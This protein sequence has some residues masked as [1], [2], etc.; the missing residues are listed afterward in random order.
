MHTTK[1]AQMPNDLPMALGE[2]LPRAD[3]LRKEKAD[4]E[5]S[6]KAYQRTVFFEKADHT[7]NHDLAGQVSWPAEEYKP[8]PP[9]GASIKANPRPPRTPP[10]SFQVLNSLTES[11]KVYQR[12]VGLKVQG[13]TLQDLTARYKNACGIPTAASIHWNWDTL[14]GF[15]DFC[16][17]KAAMVRQALAEEEIGKRRADY[18]VQCQEVD[19]ITSRKEW[20]D[21]TYDW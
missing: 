1:L 4:R 10:G 14:T 13:E 21:K 8:A 3:E 5:A 19:K 7:F 16:H 11:F 2:R 6:L 17:R 18:L 9:I 12:I 20:L 15:R